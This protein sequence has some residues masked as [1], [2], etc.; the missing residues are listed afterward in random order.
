IG[1]AVSATL[2]DNLTFDFIRDITPVAGIN[3]GF[4]V[5]VVT[6][7][8]PAKTVPELIAY[9]KANPGKINMA[10]GGIGS[11]AHLYGELFKAMTGTSLVHVPY[12][13]AGPALLDLLGGQVNIMFD[14]L[15]TSIEH[16]KA[17]RLRPLH[18]WKR[19]R[20]SL[21]WAS[22]C[23]AT[24]QKVGKV[25]VRPGTRLRRSLTSSTGRST[26]GS[27]IPGSRLGLS[28]CTTCRCR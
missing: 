8:F 19:Y 17:G 2:Y 9:A 4:G 11:V 12:R 22:S 25:S 24:Q 1:N 21:P 15:S 18:A 23:R 26:P 13:G 10:S 5:I 6:P 28:N 3:R 27:P 20:T 14:S 16:I 7:S